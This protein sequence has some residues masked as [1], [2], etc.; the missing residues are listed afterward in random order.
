MIGIESVVETSKETSVSDL[1]P[2]CNKSFERTRIL[3]ATGSVCECIIKAMF[4]RYAFTS[5]STPIRYICLQ[6]CH[7]IRLI[8][9]CLRQ[10][11]TIINV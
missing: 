1:T 7:I 2:D 8:A 3:F 11:C 9:D 6:I 10:T 5:R 4:V